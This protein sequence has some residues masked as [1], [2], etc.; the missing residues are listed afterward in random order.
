[1]AHRIEENDK[2]EGLKQ[3]WHGLTTIRE[4]MSLDKNWLREWDVVCV[5]VFLEGGK[6][7]P[8]EQIVCSDN[9]ELLIGAP[10]NPETYK[11]I[12]NADFL[13]M[14]G[15]AVS[16]TGHKLTSIGS[17]R[18]RGRTFASFEIEKLEAFTAG[19]RQFMPYLNFGNGHDKSSVLWANTSNICTVCDNTFT[20]NLFAVENK[21]SQGMKL[22][23]RHTV[24]ATARLPEM[25]KL[26]GEAIGVQREFAA[27]FE[28]LATIQVGIDSARKVFAGFVNAPDQ[29]VLTDHSEKVTNRLSELFK[30]G[31]GNKGQTRA[32]MFQAVTEFYTHENSR[33]KD[34]QAQFMSSEFGDGLRRKHEFWDIVRDESKMEKMEKRG[35]SLLEVVA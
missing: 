26:V 20:F 21:E 31:R 27:A 15:D 5:P 10:F 29:S 3:A 17:V 6:R 14:I 13:K 12:T 35:E 28:S 8:F 32:D 1:M 30:S 11:P 19:G 16:G 34:A 9:P 7:I 2:Q 24:N 4:G 22:R 23:T 33:R 18:N 25:S